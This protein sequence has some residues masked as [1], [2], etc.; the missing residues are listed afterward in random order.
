MA[1]SM[2][3]R[4]VLSIDSVFIESIC[5]KILFS[6][7]WGFLFLVNFMASVIIFF[8]FCGIVSNNLPEYS[9]FMAA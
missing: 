6:G 2:V 9:S 4:S 7:N 1:A 3:S 5:S 8:S